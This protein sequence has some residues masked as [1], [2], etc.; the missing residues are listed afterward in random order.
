[1]KNILI[2]NLS[3]FLIPLLFSCGNSSDTKENGNSGNEQSNAAADQGGVTVTQAQ[4]QGDAMQL[5]SLEKKIFPVIVEA[6]GTIDVPP[7]NKAMVSS[8]ADGY[9]KQTPLLIGDTVKKGQFLVSLENPDFVQMQQ[10][11]LDALEQMKYL[12][13]EYERQKTLM[14]ENITSEKNF[15]KAESEYKRNLSRYNALRK[16]LQMLNLDPQAVEE[17]QISSTIRLYAPIS[18]SITEMKINK[19]MYV[20]AADEILQIIDRDHLHIE[21]NVFE[22]DVMQVKKGQ[23]IRVTVPEASSDTIEG[24]VHLVGASIDEEKRTVKVHGHFKD[25]GKQHLATGMFVQAQIITDTTR[26]KALPAQSVVNVDQTDYV[27]VLQSQNDSRYVFKRREVIPG[28]SSEGFTEI[29]NS[30]DFKADD[31]FL[32][33]GAFPLITEE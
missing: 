22:K 15:L 26:T 27:L 8:Y 28:D 19:G 14:D 21:L 23:D 18:G 11:Y 4:F 10:D 33:K 13:S 1:M 12:R 3:F 25:E 5:G 9:V 31:R 6:T 2:K 30:S 16:K 29:E 24:E 17:G 7:E 32:V 20:S